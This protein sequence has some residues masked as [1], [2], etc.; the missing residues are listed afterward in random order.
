MKEKCKYHQLY[1]KN[2]SY[3]FL[4]TK[5]YYKHSHIYMTK[6]KK[7]MR[8][9]VSTHIFLLYFEIHFAPFYAILCNFTF[10]RFIEKRNTCVLVERF[11]MLQTIDY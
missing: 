3:F 7:K 4:M 9:K 2:G 5:E 1:I 8:K 11:L 10:I 6:R